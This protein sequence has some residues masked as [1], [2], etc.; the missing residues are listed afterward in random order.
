MLNPCYSSS[1]NA[2][3]IYMFN[4][5]KCLIYLMQQGWV[6]QS[7]V[8]IDSSFKSL[9]FKKNSN[10][11]FL[12]KILLLDAL[13]KKEKIIRKKTLEQKNEKTLIKI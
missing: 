10:K 7:L 13:K 12:S 4:S 2:Y 11:F 5:F 3:Y 9:L 1:P 8:K 6:V